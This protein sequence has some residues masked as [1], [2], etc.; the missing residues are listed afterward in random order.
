MTS[1]QADLEKSPSAAQVFYRFLG[2]AALGAFMVSV[3][4]WFLAIETDFLH[5]GMASLLVLS[6]GLLASVF[7]EKFIESLAQALTG[8]GL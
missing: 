6:C 7:G 3:P 4:Y 5:L 2:G 1:E 8:S